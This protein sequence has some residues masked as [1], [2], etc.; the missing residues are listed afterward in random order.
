M[1]KGRFGGPF[2]C[3]RFY[4]VVK[5]VFR[6]AE[7]WGCEWSDGFTVRAERCVRRFLQCDAAWCC[8][9]L[10]WLQS[11]VVS[12]LFG[13]ELSDFQDRAWRGGKTGVPSQPGRMPPGRGS[14]LACFLAGAA[15]VAL[16]G[17]VAA[18]VALR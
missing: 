8:S 2:F 15:V 16:M 1:K 13:N 12:C 11:K 17:P 14:V 10:W 3:L 7:G 9:R 5:G 4:A 18:D 6:A